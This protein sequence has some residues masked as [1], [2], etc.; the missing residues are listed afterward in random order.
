MTT[1]TPKR[2]P[3][4]RMPILPKAKISQSRITLLMIQTQTA[5]AAQTM[6][7]QTTTHRTA[8]LLK[9]IPVQQKVPKALNKRSITIKINEH[10]KRIP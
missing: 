6:K 9:E 7:V 1:K 4:H 8:L 5:K 2:L 3:K 10:T